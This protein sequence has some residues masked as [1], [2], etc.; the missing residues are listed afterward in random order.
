MPHFL[1]A[2]NVG[3]SGAEVVSIL[4]VE[5]F[6]VLSGYVLAPQIIFVA[7]N[8]SCWSNLGIFLVRRWMRTLPAYMLTLVVVW[9]LAH[10]AIL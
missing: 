2:Y 6:F 1:M 8:G 3:A 4:G 10:D 5:I 7:T 9:P